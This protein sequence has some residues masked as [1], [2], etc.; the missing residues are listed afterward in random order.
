V[1]SATTGFNG[2]CNFTIL[3]V[4]LELLDNSLDAG[5]LVTLE[6]A[7]LLVMTGVTGVDGGTNGFSLADGVVGVGVAVAEDAM[8]LAGLAASGEEGNGFVGFG[9]T[10]L[11]VR[12]VTRGG[13]WDRMS[14]GIL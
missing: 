1:R 7:L 13:R 11:V 14:G 8:E 12:G 4:A 10:G 6:L 5:L 3:E 2:S 9:M